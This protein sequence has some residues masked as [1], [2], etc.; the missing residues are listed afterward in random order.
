[1]ANL[2]LSIVMAV[3]ATMST[4]ML[5][6]GQGSFL[7]SG[8][9]LLAAVMSVVFTD[10]LGWF[11][12]HRVIANLAMLLAAIFSLWGFLQTDSRNQLFA[13]AHLL[14]YVQMVLLFQE[15]NRRVY[16]QLAMFSLL[17][18]VVAALLNNGLEFGVMLACYMIIALLG[19]VLFFVYREVGWVGMVTRRRSWWELG[20]LAPERL[21]ASPD[22]LPV[23]EVIDVGT[24]LNKSIV[25]RRIIPPIM[26]MF[27]VTVA[28]AIVLFY[29][30]PRT[31]GANWQGGGA[32]MNLVGFSPE[33][34]FEGMGQL[35]L[36]D[37]RVMRVSFTD[38][39]SGEPY[40]VI[41][42]PYLRGGVLTK[43]L[44]S[45]GHGRWWQESEAISMR[46]SDLPSPPNTRDLVR[47]DVLLEP[48]GN[49]RLFSMFPVYATAK[50]PAN[51]KI[52]RRAQTV[53]CRRD[54]A[55][56]AG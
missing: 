36:S 52:S 35:L 40:T 50:T 1:M 43:Y 46:G 34:S 29:T 14:I 13:I 15:K 56:N 44:S 48:T 53:S 7:L 26:A 6:M 4:T 9:T 54:R 39:R 41:G 55:G 22:G 24:V 28:F 17:Q 10:G 47:Q 21:D 5:G 8:L 19:F 30:T 18:V 20:E 42:E 51:L 12:L 32:G 27:T 3:M 31:G 11:H 45:D 23:I 16:G 2:T 33:V 25:T 38:E 49:D 37:A